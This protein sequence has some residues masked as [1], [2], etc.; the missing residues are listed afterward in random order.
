VRAKALLVLWFA[1]GVVAAEPNGTVWQGTME[2]RE[3]QGKACAMQRTPPFRVPVH[4]VRWTGSTHEETLF[5]WGDMQAAMLQ[6]ATQ[7]SDVYAVRFFDITQPD[8]KAQLGFA[9]GSLRVNWRE[10]A[11]A[12]SPG[13]N[14]TQATLSLQPVVSAEAA[15]SLMVH[16]RYLHRTQTLL[17]QLRAA[18]K[19][20]SLPLVER[21]AT[22]IG[23]IPESARADKGVAQAFLEA[24]ERAM[25]IRRP[26]QAMQM[27]QVSSGIYRRLASSDPDDAALALSREAHFLRRQSGLPAALSLMDEALAVLAAAHRENGATASHLLNLLGAWR[28]KGGQ[29]RGA[30]EVFQRAVRIDLARQA[31]NDEQAMSLNNLAQALQRAN[32]LDA[33]ARMFEQALALAELG[34]AEG[35]SLVQAIRDNLAALRNQSDSVPRTRSK[36][37]TSPRTT[38][39]SRMVAIARHL[40]IP[41]TG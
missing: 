9:G 1:A 34:P 12:Q 18:D 6:S 23:E 40:P 2:V 20:S 38:S 21:F 41:M 36:P 19:A 24:G 28:L 35:G 7:G 26:A 11:T 27:L 14:W 32:Q 31:P 5:A 29:I 33:A 4:M 17:Q 16:A 37:D 22:L 15:Q 39:D 8:G 25:A 10:S 3:Q 30:L 13:C